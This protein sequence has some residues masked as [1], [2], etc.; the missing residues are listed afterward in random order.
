M[1]SKSRSKILFILAVFV[2]WLGLIAAVPAQVP[3][4]VDLTNLTAMLVW[5]AGA[6]GAYVTGQVVSY[7]AENWPKWH[8]LPTWV[9][10]T[11]PMF[12]AA[13]ISVLATIALNYGTQLEVVAPWWSIVSY[14]VLTYLATQKAHVAQLRA[15]YGDSAKESAAEQVIFDQEPQGRG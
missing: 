14:S 7:L 10:V 13:L 15:G 11:S 3:P 8:N 9:K 1:L 6:G 4:E 12:T 2:V 5:L